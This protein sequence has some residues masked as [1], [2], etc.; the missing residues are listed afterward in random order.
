MNYKY[1]I[2]N[3]ENDKQNSNKNNNTGGMYSQKL[4]T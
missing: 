3:I 1:D 4:L 2:I